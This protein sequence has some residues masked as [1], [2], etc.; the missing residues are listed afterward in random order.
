MG[1]RIVS[2]LTECLPNH[3]RLIHSPYVLE[4]SEAELKHLRKCIEDLALR[5]DGIVCNETVDDGDNYLDRI[6]AE[7]MEKVDDED[8]DEWQPSHSDNSKGSSWSSSDFD[9]MPFQLESWVKFDEFEGKT[10]ANRKKER[11]LT[12]FSTSATVE[13]IGTESIEDDDAS[14][15]IRDHY[16]QIWEDESFKSYSSQPLTLLRK[17]ANLDFLKKVA[18]EPIIYE[19]DSDADDSWANCKDNTSDSKPSSSGGAPTSDPARLAFRNLMDKFPLKSFTKKNSK[20]TDRHPIPKSIK[21]T[22]SSPIRSTFSNIKLPLKPILQKDSQPSSKSSI[23]NEPQNDANQAPTNSPERFTFPNITLPLKW[24]MKESS[25]PLTESPIDIQPLSDSPIT[26]PPTN[27]LA[28]VV[29]RDIIEELPRESL[30]KWNCQSH[31]ESPTFTDID[32]DI[33]DQ[34]VEDEIQAYLEEMENQNLRKEVQPNVQTDRRITDQEQQQ[35]QQRRHQRQRRES[36]PRKTEKKEVGTQEFRRRKLDQKLDEQQQKIE[37]QHRPSFEATVRS[38]QT[39][40][41]SDSAS[42]G[43]KKKLSVSFDEASISTSST[44]SFSMGNSMGTPTSSFKSFGSQTSAFSVYS[45]SK[46]KQ[47]LR[48]QYNT[49]SEDQPFDEEH[50]DWINFQSG[51]SF[52]S[53]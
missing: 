18:C 22:I 49:V 38:V 23:P 6:I 19:T 43:S 28:C 8:E 27:A 26:I 17:S 42:R 20:P 24:T 14:D 48:N 13:T 1:Y 51:S 34:V 50:E 11:N 12:E 21:T 44:V 41:S 25:D 32:D 40:R 29:F 35:Q 39:F 37:Q 2:F 46:Q 36:P 47:Q 30:L 5:I 33:L 9:V 3:P 16:A 10:S 7:Q 4:Q 45:P 52:F 53:Q 31:S 15:D